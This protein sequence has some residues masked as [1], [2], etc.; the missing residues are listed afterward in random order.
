MVA[1]VR[2][3]AHRSSDWDWRPHLGAGSGNRSHPARCSGTAKESESWDVET[4]NALTSHWVFRYNNWRP[5]LT[6]WPTV[7]SEQMRWCSVW[8]RL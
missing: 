5:I 3:S 2:Q 8:P 7:S 4:W 6:F 1:N